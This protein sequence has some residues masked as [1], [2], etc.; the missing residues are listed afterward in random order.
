MILAILKG[1]QMILVWKILVR[2][3]FAGERH[4]LCRTCWD[5]GA[6]ICQCFIIIVVK[7]EFTRG[8]KI[9]TLLLFNFL[10]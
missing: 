2:G 9:L 10:L 5:S 1:K 7:R 8:W 4:E 6:R 3:N